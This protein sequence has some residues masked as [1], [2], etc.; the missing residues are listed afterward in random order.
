MRELTLSEVNVVVGGFDEGGGWSDE[1][2]YGDW[3]DGGTDWGDGAESLQSRPGGRRPAPRPRSTP[4]SRPPAQP[5]APA[6]D[7][8]PCE[9]GYGP[10]HVSGGVSVGIGP[11]SGSA[12][13]SVSECAPLQPLRPPASPPPPTYRPPTLM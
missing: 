6:P 1:G 12:Y 8:R 7:V 10:R 3:G 4:S 9:P 13:G 5:T 2:D 11:F